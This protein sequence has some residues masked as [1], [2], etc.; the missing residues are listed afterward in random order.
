MIGPRVTDLIA[1]AALAMKLEI[2][3][4]EVSSIFHLHPTLSE[5][6]WEAARNVCGG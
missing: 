3:P 1:E 5:G 6:F 4:R 2:T